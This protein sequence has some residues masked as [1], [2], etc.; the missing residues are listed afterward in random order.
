MVS[1]KAARVIDNRHDGI[2]D[3]ERAVAARL[4]AARDGHD[5]G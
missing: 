5:D 1:W 4:A 2:E 3:P